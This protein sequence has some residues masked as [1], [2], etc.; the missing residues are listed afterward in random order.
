[1]ER[2]AGRYRVE[3]TNVV[4]GVGYSSTKAQYTDLALQLGGGAWDINILRQGGNPA[5]SFTSGMVDF[6][7]EEIL[8]QLTGCRQCSCSGSGQ[9][10]CVVAPN[11]QQCSCLAA[12]NT[13]RVDSI[14]E[15][16]I[17]IQWQSF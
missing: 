15:V 5:A 10:S 8:E 6:K 17:R 1:M 12:G 14:I 3:T 11:Q 13:V 2:S 16:V 9:K 7:S 4:A